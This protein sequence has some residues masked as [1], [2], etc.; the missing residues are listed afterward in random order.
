MVPRRVAAAII[1][2]ALS[3]ASCLE[4]PVSESLDVRIRAGG[5]SEVSIG[6]VLRDPSD[7]D[8]A[9]QVR[10]RIESEARDLETGNDPWSARLRSVEPERQRDVVDRADGRLRRIVRH[11]ALRAPANLREFLRDT[12]VDVVYAE[13]EDWAELTITPGPAGRATSAQRQRIRAE[14]SVWSASLA[15]YVEATKELYDYLDRNP[16]RARVCLGTI[17]S[18]TPE[19]EAL[20]ED[21]SAL[22]ERAN[23]AIGAIGNVLDPVPGEPYTLDE[24]SRLVHDPFPAPIRVTVSGEMLEREGF[25]GELDSELRI[26][27]YSLWSAFTRLEGRWIAPDPALAMWRHDIAKIGKPFDL[28]AFLTVPRRAAPVPDENEVRGA[29]ESRLKPEPV[30]RVRWTPAENDDAVSALEREP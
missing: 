28:D 2:I 7:Y 12:G 23:D 27:A 17:L 13:G 3:S 29:I 8:G 15:T 9:P 1:L 26:P 25:P 18:E 20:T 30:Y 24:I 4:P 16:D 6:V 14:L 19:G 22:V 5:A 21:E 11:A 10:Q